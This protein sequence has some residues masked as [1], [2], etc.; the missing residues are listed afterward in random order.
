MPVAFK[1]RYCLWSWLDSNLVKRRKQNQE[2]RNSCKKYGKNNHFWKSLLSTWTILKST[3][4]AK[5]VAYCPVHLMIAIKTPKYQ[6]S[7]CSLFFQL[8]KTSF[9]WET[10]CWLTHWEN[11]QYALSMQVPFG[12]TSKLILLT[13]GTKRA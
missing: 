12:N 11:S 6:P 3:F 4:N 8:L 1:D 10:F 9:N 2:E 7:F 13:L 5:L